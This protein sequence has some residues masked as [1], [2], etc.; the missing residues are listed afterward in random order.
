MSRKR[1]GLVVGTALIAIGL[2]LGT[3]G[4]L[5]HRPPQGLGGV[6]DAV[7]RAVQLVTLD[8]DGGTAPNL[9]V[10]I[11]R[12]LTPL[13]AW[14]AFFAVALH[15]LDRQIGTFLARRRRDHIVLC[16]AGE[17][18]VRMVQRFARGEYDRIGDRDVVVVDLEPPDSRN[19]VA[20]RDEGAITISGD[21]RNPKVLRKAGLERARYVV[22][23]CGSDGTNAEIAIQARE[24]ASSSGRRRAL[25][26]FAHI[27]DATLCRLL[28]E[29]EFEM[30]SD[31][32]FRLE[33]FN[34]YASAAL[35]LLQEHPPFPVRP[36]PQESPLS[37]R[38][39]GVRSPVPPVERH[40]AVVGLDPLGKTLITGLVRQ[41]SLQGKRPGALQLSLF[42][43]GAAGKAAALS[44]ADPRIEF[45]ADVH[46][47]ELDRSVPSFDP[48]T[49]GADGRDIDIAYVCLHDD[50]E[51]LTAGL[52]LLRSM[53]PGRT[54]V[55]VTM[56]EDSGLAS[57]LRK[58]ADL[59][60]LHGFSVLDHGCTADVLRGRH[61]DL[62]RAI[63]E[64]YRRKA[65]SSDSPSVEER[66]LLPWTA[67]PETLKR[68][69]R[70]QADH[71]LRKLVTVG[72]ALAPL[73]PA[74]DESFEFEKDEVNLL[75]E[76]EHRRW[77]RERQADG[78]QLGHTKDVE[79]RI[80]PY[81]VDWNELTDDIQELDRNAVRNLPT[82]VGLAG[83]S[84]VRTRRSEIC[85]K[86]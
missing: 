68:S 36:G 11:A 58:Q 14:A 2:V 51:S 1:F 13:G 53:P 80:S 64:D 41:W 69:N 62:A 70:R 79:R 57:L 86:S 52:A 24:V 66:T 5:E 46:V 39:D 23:A 28:R 20:C 74:S 73:D 27:T 83:L 65:L 76:L 29:R 55:V 22:L 42:D 31:D 75:A 33:F 47:H 15:F 78:W 84:I 48:A 3:A 35:V 67:L 18:G 16:G 59:R 85:C 21:A 6:A 56:M 81:L 60:S 38:L 17:K 9:S 32:Q 25:R 40:V 8:L 26:C 61:E 43:R 63:H 12:V 7:Y 49:L 19:L 10:H 34:V 4:F 45:C 50:I 30:G 54:P 71:V 82:L 77:V 44:R 72:C 37:R